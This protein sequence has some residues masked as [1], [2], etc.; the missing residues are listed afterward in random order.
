MSM[1]T[2]PEIPVDIEAVHDVFDLLKKAVAI[3]EMG[4]RIDIMN[5][6]D[7]EMLKEAH[8]IVFGMLLDARSKMLSWTEV[9]S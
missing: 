5:E 3:T 2:Y 7:S 4:W 1:T 6:E 8:H 9:R